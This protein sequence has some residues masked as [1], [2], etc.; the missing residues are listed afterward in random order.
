MDDQRFDIFV[1]VL[2]TGSSRRTVL[3]GLGGGALGGVLSLFT[4]EPGHAAP[5]KKTSKKAFTRH[6][7]KV[8]MQANGAACAKF[9]K[10]EP[11]GARGQ[12]QRNCVQTGGDVTCPAGTC[13]TSTFDPTTGMCSSPINAENGGS[14]TNCPTECCTGLCCPADQQCCLA[15]DVPITN[16][17]PGTCCSPQG[18]PGCVTTTP[19]CTGIGNCV[20]GS[21]R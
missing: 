20:E 5:K 1:R 2:G 8:R 17:N 11:P 13:Q 6:G 3:M 12:C 18:T 4:Q 15:A 19:C 9:C 14:G 7:A 10:N 21:C 16:C